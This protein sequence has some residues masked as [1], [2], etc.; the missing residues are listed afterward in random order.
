MYDK[1]HGGAYDRG[2]A[3]RH[4]GRAYDPHYYIGATYSTPRVDLE[5]MTAAE[6]AE[7]TAGYRD[8]DTEKDWD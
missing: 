1:R 7:Y 8:C 4:Y 5:R 2:M 3:D 6:I